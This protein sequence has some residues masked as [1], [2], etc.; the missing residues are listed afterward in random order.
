[1]KR[2]PL[3]QIKP[4]PK[5]RCRTMDGILEGF[6]NYIDLF[7]DIEPPEKEELEPAHI[8]KE[9]LAREQVEANKAANKEATTKCIFH[10]ISS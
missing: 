1:M 5:N 2:P 10:N 7:E 6:K 4:P 9:R 8:K 3:T